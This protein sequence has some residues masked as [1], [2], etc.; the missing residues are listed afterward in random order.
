VVN[1]IEQSREQPTVVGKIVILSASMARRPL[2]AT[3]LH[4]VAFTLAASLFVFSV[5]LVWTA[6]MV[7]IE[8][9]IREGT[10]WI[11]VLAKRAGI[12][13]YDGSRV[14]F[15]N[16]NHGPMDAILK[17]WLSRAM[18][19]LPG[20]M[21]LRI[22]VLLGP[23]FLLAAAYQ[24]GRRNLTYAMVAAATFQL[25]Q[26]NLTNM[27]LVGRSDATAMCGLA[28]CAVCVHRIMQGQLTHRP[29]WRSLSHPVLLGVFS[30]VVFLAC[31]RHALILSVLLFLALAGAL[32]RPAGHRLKILLLNLGLF[33]V[34]FALVWG[35]T[36]VFELHGNLTLYHKRY[37][38]FF[39]AA[40]GWGLFVRGA[41]SYLP[42]AV[43]D[44]RRPILLLVLGLLLLAAYRMRRHWIELT[45]W[46]AMLVATWGAHAYVYYKNSGGGGIHYFLPFF[47]L[48][49]FFMLHVLSRGLW[50]RR[51]RSGAWVSLCARLPVLRRFSPLALRAYA[52]P[53]RQL[54]LIGLVAAV[55]PWHQLVNE[56]RNLLRVRRDTLSFLRAAKARADGE[57]IFSEDIHLYKNKY[58]GEVVDTGDT[59]SAIAETGYYGK[60]LSRTYGDY[61]R[62]LHSDP[63]G[64]VI[65]GLLNEET[66]SGV[67]SPDLNGLLFSQYEIVLRL[68]GVLVA[69][70]GCEIALFQKKGR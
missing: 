43:V 57:V 16:M 9:E 40:S 8:L 5:W 26:V 11:Y 36:L 56:G 64:F 55:L 70:G 37:F 46:L 66:H 48:A 27:S 6:F 42:N 38:G 47:F 31:W 69:N 32:L 2:L 59:V 14:A 20:A 12:D 7:P 53:V 49:W 60:A 52:K 41:F 1:N 17:G 63:P 13:I 67:L 54:I 18:P 10:E 68:P 33:V 15:V 30:A 35:A 28:L 45:A 61:R 4:T 62:R 44:G 23:F 34:G 51:R 25:F 58:R 29:L 3:V 21:V 24:I 22:F 65:A 50:S 19:F 39:S